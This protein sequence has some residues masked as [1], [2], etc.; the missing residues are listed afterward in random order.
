M[1]RVGVGI[2]WVAWIMWNHSI[3]GPEGLERIMADEWAPLGSYE[4]KE[5]CE[6]AILRVF[7]TGTTRQYKIMPN[8]TR[9]EMRTVFHCYP[10]T[11]DPRGPKG[12]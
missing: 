7:P 3:A 9:G 1:K 11:F 10:D 2:L 4:S 12:K 5:D 8:G 6:R